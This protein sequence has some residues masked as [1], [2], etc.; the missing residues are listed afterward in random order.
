LLLGDLM[1]LLCWL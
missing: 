1:K